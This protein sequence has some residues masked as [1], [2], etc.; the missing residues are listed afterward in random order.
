M[1]TGSSP[2][3]VWINLSNQYIWTYYIELEALPPPSVTDQIRG[4]WKL[5]VR[6]VGRPDTVKTKLMTALA[7]I[8]GPAGAGP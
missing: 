5:E 8:I 4:E 6:E 3:G 2:T 1:Y 7:E